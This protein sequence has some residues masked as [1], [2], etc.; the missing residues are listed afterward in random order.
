MGIP[1]AACRPVESDIEK[2]Y[3]ITWTIDMS[4]T[5]PEEAARKARDIQ[6]REDG[7]ADVF[8][9]EHGYDRHDID[10]SAIEGRC[11]D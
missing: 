9:V 2:E 3:R 11:V 6:L 7:I 4:A 8:T 5:S 1:E 10:L